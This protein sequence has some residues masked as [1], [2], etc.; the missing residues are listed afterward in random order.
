MRLQRY[1]AKTHKYVHHRRKE[2]LPQSRT[3]EMVVLANTKV[4]LETFSTYEN[5]NH[6]VDICRQTGITEAGK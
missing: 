6:L 4:F 2:S 3:E 1:Q 5:P